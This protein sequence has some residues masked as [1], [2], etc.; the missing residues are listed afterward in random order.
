MCVQSHRSIICVL[1]WYIYIY[2][3][4]CVVWSVQLFIITFLQSNFTNDL[5][6]QYVHLKQ[7][8][9]QQQQQPNPYRLIISFAFAIL[10]LNE[11]S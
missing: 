5:D 3:Y 8:E 6:D 7:R 10:L 11:H 4:I 9:Q 2:I 1:D